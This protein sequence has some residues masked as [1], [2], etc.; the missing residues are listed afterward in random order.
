[1]P[2]NAPIGP[3]F[4]F[5]MNGTM[6][7]TKPCATRPQ[8]LVSKPLMM[9]AAA[10]ALPSMVAQLTLALKSAIKIGPIPVT[11]IKN[12]VLIAVMTDSSPLRKSHAFEMSSLPVFRSSGNVSSLKVV[13][14]VNTT[15]LSS[16]TIFAPMSLLCDLIEVHKPCQSSA[17][18]RA[19]M[20]ENVSVSGL[21]NCIAWL[22]AEE[23]PLKAAA[24]K[25]IAGVRICTTLIRPMNPAI[26]MPLMMGASASAAACRDW[27]NRAQIALCVSALA[28]SA[29]RWNACARNC[30]NG[31]TVSPRPLPIAAAKFVIDLVMFTKRLVE[32]FDASF[33]LPA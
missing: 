33:R 18:M 4:A 14:A 24:R 6:S 17:L 16:S 8:S 23:I 19:A 28:Y 15:C 5:A 10:I 32:R 9:S 25:Y 7:S 30:K 20:R 27:V 11:F 12:H 26:P 29:A 21:R 31:L 13:H 2:I 3:N 1:M 22:A